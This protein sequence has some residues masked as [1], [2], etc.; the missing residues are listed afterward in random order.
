MQRFTGAIGVD[1][2]SRALFDH[3]ADN[4]EMW[5]GDGP[6]EVRVA[7]LFRLAFRERP[8]VMIGISMWDIDHRTNARAEIMAENVT[9]S[10]FDIVF[11]SWSDT[12]VARIRADWLAIGPAQDEDHWEVP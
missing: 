5:T 9:A 6:R 3:F 12:R 11:R 4:G 10:G 1:Q 2:G 7:Q 8:V